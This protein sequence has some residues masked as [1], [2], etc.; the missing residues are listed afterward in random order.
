MN[1]RALAASN[2]LS[3]TSSACITPGDFDAHFAALA[4]PAAPRSIAVAISGGAD[5]LCL[6]LLLHEYCNARGIRLTALTVDHSLRPESASEAAHV[7]MWMRSLGLEHHTLVWRHDSPV[8]ANIQSTARAARYRLLTQFCRDQNILHLATAHHQDD[9]VETL[10]MRKQRG[11]GVYGQACM[12]AL[13]W[14]D[15]VLLLRPLL[16]VRKSQLIGTLHA[17]HHPWLE[18]PSNHHPRFSRTRVRNTLAKEKSSLDPLL[19][20]IETNTRSRHVL[21]TQSARLLA[22]TAVLHCEGY[23][24]IA[25]AHWRQSPKEITRRAL[26]QL[27]ETVSGNAF[28]PR[29]SSLAPLME[30]LFL[31]SPAPWRAT[32]H[33]CVLE[34]DTARLSVYREYSAV[35]PP[36][37]MNSAAVRWDSRFVVSLP[38]PIFGLTL[39][40]L[41]PD[42]LKILRSQN[43][44][45]PTRMK[46]SILHTL[47]SLWRLEA[48]LSVPHIDYLAD[49]ALGGTHTHF[50]PPKALAAHPF[51]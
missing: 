28:P 44:A 49:A 7:A 45:I 6:A 40:A 17:H 38:Q 32:L 46:S 8:L 14:R 25:L 34:V 39:K 16:H 2:A 41:G 42:G 5:S 22:E 20:Q 15:G 3:G 30:K 33:G 1:A 51:W 35:Q 18:D 48:L 47:P 21:D 43:H 31:P 4:L 19:R 12:P 37:S 23:A 24:D 13:S 27:L 36:V 50:H 11:A 9:Q 29:E 10:L 26:I